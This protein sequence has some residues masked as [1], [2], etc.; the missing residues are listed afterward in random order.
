MN[1]KLVDLSS[2][3][4]SDDYEEQMSMRFVMAWRAS[5][6]AAEGMLRDPV[7]RPL[8]EALLWSIRTGVML[9]D[10]SYANLGW[11]AR[12]GER[13]LVIYDPG[14]TVHVPVPAKINPAPRSQQKNYRLEP[15]EK[16]CKMTTK[17]RNPT[18]TFRVFVPR[19]SNPAKRRA[20]ASKYGPALKLTP[21]PID[22]PYATETKTGRGRVQASGGYARSP[23]IARRQI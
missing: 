3:E 19:R 4:P 20:P 8:A 9:C 2:W 22:P 5:V 18:R 16:A 21:P 7:L 1:R 14:F 11:V 13:A 17:R 12:N 23:R 15:V 6:L 10:V